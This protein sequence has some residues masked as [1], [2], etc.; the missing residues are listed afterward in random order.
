MLSPERDPRQTRRLAIVAI[1]VVVLLFA[2]ELVALAL[3]A[4]ELA[5]GCAVV[6]TIAWFVLRSHRRRAQRA[7]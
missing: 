1:V 5:V 4:L 7:G 6:L 3:G 2:V